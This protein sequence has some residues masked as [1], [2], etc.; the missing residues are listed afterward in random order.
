MQEH[1]HVLE[2]PEHF[3]RALDR[4]A[5]SDWE[6]RK[7]KGTEGGSRAVQV[8][9]GSAATAAWKG[10]DDQGSEGRDGSKQGHGNY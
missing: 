6:G 7:R 10:S 2:L 5:R 8:S 9:K 1:A 3:I 4:E